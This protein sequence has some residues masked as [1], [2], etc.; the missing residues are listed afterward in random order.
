MAVISRSPTEPF[1]TSGAMLI[2]IADDEWMNRELMR[3]FL[4][5]AGYQ[6]IEAR[7]GEQA[8][9][10][11][12]EHHPHM[13]L[14]DVRMYDLDGFE[15]CEQLKADPDTQHIRIVML[16]ALSEMYENERATAAGAAAFISKSTD[17]KSIMKRIDEIAQRP[18]D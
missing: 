5:R 11:A 10:M 15:V 4:V 1:T 6:V 2:L 7:N 16:S 13:M 9:A 12:R 8:L 18:D 17:W 14:L 3:T